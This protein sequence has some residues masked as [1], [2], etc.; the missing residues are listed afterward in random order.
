MA[1]NQFTSKCLLHH[2]QITTITTQLTP[3]QLTPIRKQMTT[4]HNRTLQ[5]QL[6]LVLH[7]SI[8]IPHINTLTIPIIAMPTIPDIMTILQ[9]I[10]RKVEYI[11]ILVLG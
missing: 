6:N 8:I 3:T 1:F 9:Y 11:F 4:L 5:R 7:T 10:T 2:H